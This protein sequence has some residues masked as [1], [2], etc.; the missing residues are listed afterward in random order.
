MC[1]RGSGCG[2]WPTG[3]TCRRRSGCWP[4]RSDAPGSTRGHDGLILARGYRLRVPSAPAFTVGNVVLLRIDDDALARRPRLLVHEARHA[5]QYA[6]CVG[7]VML[8]LYGLAA[9]WSWLRCRNPATYNVFERLA[10]SC[11]TA[12][13]ACR[14]VSGMIR[15]MSDATAG[16]ARRPARRVEP[17]TAVLHRVRRRLAGRDPR[18]WR[19]GLGPVVDGQRRAGPRRRRLGVRGAHRGRPGR[20]PARAARPARPGRARHR[21]SRRADAR[22]RPGHLPPRLQRD[23]QL[24]AVVRAPP[25]L[26]DADSA[27]LRRRL[28]PRVERLR[29]LQPRL[30]GGARGRGVV[31]APRCSSRTTT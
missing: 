25:A 17:G 6:W 27:G 15:A 14:W 29:V 19:A 7:L 22:H 2:R 26:R 10:G 5:T 28:P 21:R 1:G 12:A 24:D 9:A 23:R 31:R 13:T 3:S 18:R 20:R 16:T 4:R 11:R 8:P 30:R